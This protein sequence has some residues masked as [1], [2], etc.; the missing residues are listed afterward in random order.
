MN[1]T[2]ENKGRIDRTADLT[3][4][5]RQ[6]IVRAMSNERRRLKAEANTEVERNIIKEAGKLS[7]QLKEL[8]K[9]LQGWIDEGRFPP[10]LDEEVAEVAG[11]MVCN[12]FKSDLY[13]SL[14]TFRKR[15]LD[16]GRSKRHWE[17]GA[18]RLFVQSF[19]FGCFGFGWGGL[20]IL[21]S[22]SDVF[23]QCNPNP[24]KVSRVDASLSPTTLTTT[25][26]PRDHLP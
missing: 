17:F 21:L 7:I 15:F 16:S 10:G 9:S 4:L 14:T 8:R 26:P 23:L 25:T 18:T 11:M 13:M 12:P 6:Q 3:G 19:V 1:A 5:T 22:S 2:K 20:C 24:R